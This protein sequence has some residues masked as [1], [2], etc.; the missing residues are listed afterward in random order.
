MIGADIG[1]VRYYRRRG[2]V[3]LPAQVSGRQ[4]PRLL[5]GS[6]KGGFERAGVLG[7]VQQCFPSATG[8]LAID[9][10]CVASRAANP[11]DLRPREHCWKEN[12]IRA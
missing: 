9:R 12:L 4:R 11:G 8:L 3:E 2:A 6:L 7:R 5:R 1:I 10:E